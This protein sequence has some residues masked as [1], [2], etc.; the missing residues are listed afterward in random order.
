MYLKY[1]KQLVLAL[2]TGM[3]MACGGGGGGTASSGITAYGT[4]TG[5]GSIFINGIEFETGSSSISVDDNPGNESDLQLGMVVTVTGTLDPGGRTGTASTV[6]FDDEVQGPIATVPVDPT[7]DGQVLQ[8]TIL[9]V[10]VVAD[11]TAT[12]FDNSVSFATLAQGDFVEVS[13]FIGQGGVLNATRI[14]GKGAFTPGISEI[15]IKGLA[16]NVVVATFSL[17]VFTVDS[18][19]A[20]LS[21][22][23]GGVVTDGMKVEVKGTLNGTSIAA[24]RVKQEDDLFSA[25]VD[26]VSLEGIITGYVDDG[27]FQVSGQQV[28]ASSA[29]FSPA[30]LVL[31]NGI[32][33]EVEGPIVN[34]VL[35]AIKAEPRGGNIKIQARV[36]SVGQNSLTMQFNGGTV[37]VV[38][39]TQTSL[40]DD[41]G[42]FDPYVL[43]DVAATD[44]LEIRGSINGNGIITAEEIRRDNAGDDILQGPAD[45]CVGT[46]LTVLGIGF[47]LQDGFTTY[48]DQ[49]DNPIANAANFCSAVNASSLAVKVRDDLSPNGIA[50]E[51]EL[52]N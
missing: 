14:E 4:I 44:F 8:F 19:G 43:G 1:L 18:S 21:G 42:I 28:D 9:G 29:V 15:E 40:R 45:S 11:R 13:G 50:D 20:D 2:V 10:T 5:F 7:G 6:S 36:Q 35:L 31:A 49:F 51:A 34:G 48:Q 25:N 26:K 37:D 12:V 52:E 33:V 22:V 39:D 3:L 41:L 46:T 32:E 24:S 16:G 17:G 30:N 23:P 27:N 38:V 47:T